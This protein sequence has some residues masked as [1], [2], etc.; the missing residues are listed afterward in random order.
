MHRAAFLS[1][2][3]AVVFFSLIPT[4][5]AVTPSS[6][7]LSSAKAEASSLEAQ[8]VALDGQMKAAGG[9]YT[10]ARL[11]LARAQARIADN[12]RR[13]AATSR[14][15]AVDRRN[16]ASSA[17]AMYKASPAGVLDVL[18]AS[19]DFA[20]LANGLD[21]MKRINRQGAAI[22]DSVSAAKRS[23]VRRQ[24]VLTAERG[25]A[26]ALV[27][28]VAQQEAQIK[29]ALLARQ[30]LLAKAQAKVKTI[31]RQIAAARAAAARAAAARAAAAAAQ[32]A[33]SSLPLGP[34]AGDYSPQTWAQAFLRNARLPV[35]ASNV[36]AIVS[37]EAAEGGHWVNGAHF[38]P[39]N[40]TMPEPGATSMNSVGVKAYTSWAQGFTATVATLYNG[41]YPGIIAALRAGTDA[42]AV[43]N[44]VG[45]SPW[46]TLPFIV[47]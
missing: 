45:A 15:L 40:T 18:L 29:S 13:L 42:Q 44:A 47:T 43:A 24:N 5:G 28:R 23:I 19:N 4:A 17:V 21:A 34:T 37:W 46:G 35:T 1:G 11:Q 25:Q 36:R 7:S 39:L 9:R 3:L 41:N 32:A 31:L 12:E 6:K 33:G 30:T 2:V 38:N 8:M 16:L 10:E 26:K 14:E 27:A 22:V 20:D